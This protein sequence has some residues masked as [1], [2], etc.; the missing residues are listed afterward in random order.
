MAGFTGYDPER[1]S[2]VVEGNLVGNMSPE[3]FNQI[4]KNVTGQSFT[5]QQAPAQTQT[6]QAPVQAQAQAQAQQAQASPQKALLYGGDGSL[7][8]LI[9]DQSGAADFNVEIKALFFKD[10]DTGRV[11]N[12]DYEDQEYKGLGPGY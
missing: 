7:A 11:F 2:Y 12:Y 5:G 4:V 3:A 8:K 9:A 6:Q 10:P 1:N